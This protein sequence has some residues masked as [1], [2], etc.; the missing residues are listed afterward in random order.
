[1]AGKTE[2]MNETAAGTTQPG[3]A[4]WRGWAWLDTRLER[5]GE[6][7][8]PILVKEA[9]QAM[10]SRQFSITFTLLL[11]FGLF[12]S[13]LGVS[14]QMPGIYYAPGGAQMLLGYF[15]ILLIPM[16][17]VVPFAAYRSLA[18]E[19]EDGT[20]ELLS[21]TSLSARRIVSGKLGSVLLQML[22]YYSALGPSIAFTYL[23]RGVD[24]LTIAFVMAITLLL[25][26]M[27]SLIGLF[28]ASLARGRH[29]QL[30][31]SVVLIL[32]CGLAA[33]GWGFIVTMLMVEGSGGPFQ[34]PEF[35]SV[36]AGM[37]TAYLTYFWVL[38]AAT[39]SLNTFAAENRSTRL[40]IAVLVQLAVCFGWICFGAATFATLPTDFIYTVI[41]FAAGHW[42]LYGTLMSGE[43]PKLSPRVARQLPGTFLGRALTCWFWP[44]P[45]TGYVFSVGAFGVFLLA[46]ILMVYQMA[47]NWQDA[48]VWGSLVWGYLAT[49]LAIGR[50]ILI[51][52]RRI[53]PRGFV[54]PVLINTLILLAAVAIPL[55]IEAF[56]AD[57][58][59]IRGY[60]WRQITNWLWTF[61]EAMGNSRGPG[62]V[63]I[64]TTVA[65]LVLICGIV[66]FVAMLFLARGAVMQQQRAVPQRVRE[67]ERQP[68][69]GPA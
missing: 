51:P 29:W 28:L 27:L 5:A 23:L 3:W 21:V 20:Y 19:R 44:G 26:L 65:P 60:S 42:V 22:V 59:Y 9:R 47:G 68:S 34:E 67:D 41:L 10:K 56:T 50:L 37:G 46:V 45:A 31:I 69:H 17:L 53:S 49:Y 15:Y 16:M 54:L 48:A 8:N 57:F 4:A 62:T 13:F 36:M 35:W 64:P 18:A 43:F 38:F 30:M 39:E 14:M 61:T 11:T 63:L 40:R 6:W 2:T 33:W 12:W 24:V 55:I 32:G 1:M 7:L 52:A 25:S 58:R 66:S